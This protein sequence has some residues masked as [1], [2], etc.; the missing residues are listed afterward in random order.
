MTAKKKQPTLR[1]IAKLAGVSYQTV[2]LVVNGKPGVS[3]L[4]RQ[5][6]LRLLDELDYHPNYAAQMLSTRRSNT[7]ELIVV[8]VRYSGQLADA[9]TNMVRA[10]RA[11]GYSL[12]ITDT[13]AA[14]LPAA[15][16]R[17]AAR[18]TDG[19][20]LFAPRLR[21]PDADLI[22]MSGGIPIVRRDYVPGSALVWVG[23]D[24]TY[25]TRLAVEH[26]IGLGHRHI[27]AIPPSA[28]LLN[29]YWRAVAWRSVLIE[30]GLTPG[31]LVEGDYTMRSG[32]DAAH[33]IASGDQPFTA[34]VVGSDSM[35]LGALRALRER[36]L[37]VPED[38]SIVGYDNSELAGYTTPALT[39]VGFQFAKQD[40]LAVKYLLDLIDDPQLE[41][42][43]HALMASLIVRESSAAPTFAP[44]RQR[45]DTAGQS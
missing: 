10:A 32:Y 30:N 21:I 38:V 13:T 43:Q 6:I 15:F 41:P 19:A 35:A 28:D 7:L 36:G 22:A 45:S 25:A 2:S 27:A 1:D 37:R 17:A 14:E 39:S 9:T 31:A 20:L 3:D 11:A 16:E 26:L 8:D 24:Q 40:E 33:Q 4:T 44:P 34:L 12:L 42:H 23:F 18:L 29:G 5:R